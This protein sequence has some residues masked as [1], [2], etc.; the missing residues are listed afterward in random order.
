MERMRGRGGV[1]GESETGRI[2]GPVGRGGGG[3]G[4]DGGAG[5]GCEIVGRG[6]KV[7]GRG[8][9]ASGRDGAVGWGLGLGVVILMLKRGGK[10]VP[11]T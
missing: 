2:G 10:C 4:V 9:Y 7:V 6:L 3:G 5:R 1:V 11:G 8:W